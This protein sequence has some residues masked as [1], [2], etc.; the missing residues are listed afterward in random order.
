[1][2]A[3]PQGQKGKLADEGGR[4]E[5]MEHG[6][7]PATPVSGMH[8]AI[9][10][11]VQEAVQEHLEVWCAAYIAAQ[12]ALARRRPGCVRALA[13]KVSPALFPARV[14]PGS[15]AQGVHE[16]VQDAVTEAVQAAVDEGMSFDVRANLYT[17]IAI[18]GLLDRSSRSYPAWNEAPA[19]CTLM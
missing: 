1:M 14:L 11:A 3:A 19:P 13:C 10:G 7:A 4:C 18:T 6:S 9:Q 12:R 2:H 17:L 8:Q 5:S 16:A 15:G